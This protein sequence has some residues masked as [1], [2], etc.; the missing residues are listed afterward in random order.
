MPYFISFISLDALNSKNFQSVILRFAGLYGGNRRIGQFLAQGKAVENPKGPV[1]LVH[2]EDCV[3]VATQVILKGIKGEIFNVCSD[4]HPTRED[5]YTKASLSLGL[6][7]PQFRGKQEKRVKIV[8][9]AKLKA[10]LDY[11]FIH[12]DPLALD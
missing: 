1:N 5:I 6:A 4:A 12:P 7:P 3:A 11:Q 10:K 8:S 9:N 2:L